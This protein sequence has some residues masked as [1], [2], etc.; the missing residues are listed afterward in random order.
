MVRQLLELASNCM[1]FIPDQR[2]TMLQVYLTVAA[3]ARVHDL[4][5]NPEIQL[6]VD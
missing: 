5:G 1:K 2:P 4:T 3:L 6:H